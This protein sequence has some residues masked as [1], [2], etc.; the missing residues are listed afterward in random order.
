MKDIQYLKDN[1]INI[2]SS[3]ELFGDINLY[4][5]AVVDYLGSLPNKINDLIS[6]KEASDLHNYAILVHSLK[7]DA[8]F[9]GCIHLSEIALNHEMESKNNNINYIFYH[10]DDLINEVNKVTNILTNY[11]G[12]EEVHE[13]VIKP[14]E[15]Q[16]KT[17]LIVD[18]SD[19]IRNYIYK[20]FQ[21]SYNIIVAKD[22]KEAIDAITLDPERKIFAMLLDLNMPN[23]DGFEVLRFLS[24]N[25]YFNQI[26]VTI[27]TGEDT[28]ENIKEAFNYPI[29]D[30]ISKP[31]NETN[32]KRVIEHS[33]SL[34]NQQ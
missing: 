31:F 19:I 22:G 26:A 33:I 15:K 11:I 17:I 16:D 14:A 1:N 9:L 32:I 8:K 24:E 2:D 10:F 34:N 3:L 25:N 28:K 6:F 13:I 20:I 5:E 12:E 4:N 23:V 29:V 18:D 30:V 27:V 21:D 7:S